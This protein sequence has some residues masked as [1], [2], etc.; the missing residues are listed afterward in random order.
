V[1]IINYGIGVLTLARSGQNIN[2]A[3]SNIVGSAGTA[4]SPTGWTVTSDGTNYIAAPIGGSG[5]VSITSGPIASRPGSPGNAGSMYYCTDSPYTYLSNGSTWDA[6]I[7][8][9]KV[10]E[11]VMANFTQVNVGLS[12][13]DTTHGGI[14]WSA[15]TAGGHNVQV[16]TQTAGIPASGAYYVDAAFIASFGAGNGAF[17]A[18]L[19]GGL[20]AS[21]SFAFADWGG[22][23]NSQFG[24]AA[25]FYNTTTS[26]NG[27]G[28]F[29]NMWPLAAPLAWFRMFD[30]RVT[31]RTYYYSNNGYQWYQIYSEP[32]TTL[33]TPAF[34]TVAI[35]NFSTSAKL[36]LHFVHFSIHT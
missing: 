30:D 24:M 17:G 14:L 34:G 23:N 1:T 31:T 18:G 33:F 25:K 22:E 28:G 21:S 12:T 36:L 11:P 16:L 19:A 15:G 26:Y 9:Y 29:I 8:G 20:L 4:L 27:S 7:F 32:R 5:G 3:A 2:G 35:T 6:Y 13:F 10:V